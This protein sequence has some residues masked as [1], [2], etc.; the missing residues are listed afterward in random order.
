[1]E[2]HFDPHFTWRQG[3]Y[4]EPGRA[5]AVPARLHLTA[6]FDL[7]K[8]EP[9]LEVVRGLTAAFDWAPPSGGPAY[10]RWIVSPMLIVP[11]ALWPR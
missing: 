5:R 4:V 1:M 9:V 3:L 8:D 11:E 7:T 2:S 10:F 6:G